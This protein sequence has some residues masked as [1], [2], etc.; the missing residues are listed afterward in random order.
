MRLQKVQN[1][2]VRFI[3]GN[4]IKKW[5]HVSPFLKKAHFLPIKQ[6]ILF[7]IALLVYKCINNLAPPY[8]QELLQ[9]RDPKVNHLRIDK[10]YFL[11]KIPPIPSLKASENA[12]LFSGPRVWNSL[13]YEIR[14]SETIDKFKSKL[15]TY[16][17]NSV[18]NNDH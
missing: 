7:K 12:F 17:F 11:L 13:P 10:D 9:L 14:C 16:Y 6:R 3:Y 18:F 1:Q 8:L 2:A 5:D 15:K 4:L